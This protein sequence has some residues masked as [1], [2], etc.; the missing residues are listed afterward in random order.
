M[1]GGGSDLDVGVAH[2]AVEVELLDRA[3]ISQVHGD[4]RWCE[5]EAGG[6]EQRLI[7]RSMAL[8]EHGVA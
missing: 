5:V 2:V 6:C 4:L 1:R 7:W 8:S 3:E